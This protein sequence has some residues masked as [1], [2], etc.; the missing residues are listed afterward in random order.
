MKQNGL[1][2][3]L[4]AL[5]V[6][7]TVFV[8]TGRV[9]AKPKKKEKAAAAE[10]APIEAA[11]ALK[12]NKKPKLKYGMTTK[13]VAK[14]YD[15]VIDQDYHKALKEAEPGIQEER[16][17]NEIKE[18][19]RVFRQS[20]IELDHSPSSLDGG[21]FE[22]EFGYGNEEGFMKI[23]RKGKWRYFFFWKKRLYKVIDF[24]KLGQSTKWGETFDTAVAKMEEGIG[25]AGRKLKADENAG[26]IHDEVDWAD[27]T[28]HFRLV[29]WTTRKIAFI[30]VDKSKEAGI[31]EGRAKAK[32]KKEEEI[33]PSVKDA[34][35]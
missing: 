31:A 5:L 7:L 23:N 32:E 26:R 16:V 18:K 6:G 34:L 13:E 15:K 17:K 28:H 33:D 24:A 4:L 3:M 29:S 20:Y 11:P 21:P 1:V 22:G 12:P 2:A 25:T 35:R 19:K 8:P 9:D 10:P 30:W 27:P 14:V